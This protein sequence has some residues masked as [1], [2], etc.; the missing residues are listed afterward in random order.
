MCAITRMLGG[1]SQFLNLAFWEKK[2]GLD[3]LGVQVAVSDSFMDTDQKL[4]N[5]ALFEFRQHSY[6]CL[7]LDIVMIHF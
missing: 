2:F 7:E 5:A 3:L 1:K 4:R 6:S